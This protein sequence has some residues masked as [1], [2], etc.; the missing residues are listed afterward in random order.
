MLSDIPIPGDSTPR[1]V[2]I[3]EGVRLTVRDPSDESR[4]TNVN[5]E[6]KPRAS[7]RG[8]V[9][10]PAD[11]PQQLGRL[12]SYMAVRQA[13]KSNRESRG[14]SPPTWT[15]GGHIP[16]G[17]NHGTEPPTVLIPPLPVPGA[18]R[19]RPRTR[20]GDGT[21]KP[22]PFAVVYS[23]ATG[24]GRVRSM[25]RPVLPASKGRGRTHPFGRSPLFRSGDRAGVEPQAGESATDWR[26]HAPTAPTWRSRTRYSL[27]GG[28]YRRGCVGRPDVV[29]ETAGLP[30]SRNGEAVSNAPTLE[31]SRFSAG[32]MSTTILRAAG[33]RI[34]A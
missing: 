12:A 25:A 8:Q 18:G 21:P 17:E 9:V 2:E 24:R 10:G 23:A 19:Q 34:D 26:R 33:G 13:R 28:S 20:G 27:R 30:S 11:Q 29:R 32:R 14:H 31:S 15:R 3:L 22:A 5:F 1:D 16:W 6:R 4:M 7:G